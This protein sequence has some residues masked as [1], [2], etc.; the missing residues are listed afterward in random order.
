MSPSPLVVTKQINGDLT[1]TND[2]INIEMSC[3]R[4]N[5]KCNYWVSSLK[6][7]YDLTDVKSL[8]SIYHLV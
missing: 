7:S 4:D 2:E 8:A 3:I 5:H 6:Y 1:N